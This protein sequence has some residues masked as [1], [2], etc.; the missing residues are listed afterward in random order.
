[1]PFVGV[2]ERRQEESP[3]IPLVPDVIHVKADVLQ[4]H[5]GQK[6]E[7]LE[8]NGDD[9]SD[10]AESEGRDGTSFEELPAQ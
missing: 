9:E 6:R 3:V 5:V 8:E 1:M 10:Q 7:E 4:S 2:N